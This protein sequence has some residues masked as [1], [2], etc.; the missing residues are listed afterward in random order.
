MCNNNQLLLMKIL[1][2]CNVP[3]SCRL[4]E[5]HSGVLTVLCPGR[6][7]QHSHGGVGGGE[8]GEE[9]EE[10]Q[11]EECHRTE[12]LGGPDDQHGDGHQHG[13]QHLPARQADG[14]ERPVHQAAAQGPQPTPSLNW[15]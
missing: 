10:E 6:E 11:S 2:T 5:S 14:Q 13:G 7:A 3:V 8:Q 4:V 12:G 9:E 1:M 15:I